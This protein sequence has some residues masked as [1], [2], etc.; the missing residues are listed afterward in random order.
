MAPFSVPIHCVAHNT[1]LEVKTLSMQSLVDNIEKLLAR[2]YSYFSQ[3]SKKAYELERLVALLDVKGLKILWIVKM[4]WLLM[5]SPAKKVL[6]ESKPFIMKMWA[7]RLACEIINVNI[8][9]LF[10]VQ[11]L[12]GFPCVMPLLELL[13]G[14]IKMAQTWDIYVVNF[15][16]DVKLV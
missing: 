9:V 4:W 8:I 14:I 5:L 3:S 13:N 7:N 10:D 11:V 16:E 15:V 2:V 12:L 6:T 1:N